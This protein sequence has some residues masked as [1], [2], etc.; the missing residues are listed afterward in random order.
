MKILL[1]CCNKMS[2]EFQN[3]KSQ[4]KYLVKLNN[5]N[6]YGYNWNSQDK[7]FSTNRNSVIIES[8]SKTN[9]NENEYFDWCNKK[10]IDENDS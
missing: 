1:K 10:Q 4:S 5:Q 7:I 9:I 6:N 2:F 3:P 8:R